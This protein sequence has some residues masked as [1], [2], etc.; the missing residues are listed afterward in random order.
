LKLKAAQSLAL[1]ALMGSRTL[2]PAE[3]PELD[4][5]PHLWSPEHRIQQRLDDDAG[6]QR[7]DRAVEDGKLTQR[8]P[9]GAIY[10]DGAADP[11][12]LLPWELF[13]SL[14]MRTMV[15]EDPSRAL[16]RGHFEQVR[17]R[18]GLPPTFWT[19]LESVAGH[20]VG[21][22]RAQMRLASEH[23]KNAAA[24]AGAMALL[25]SNDCAKR[26]QALA[27]ARAR[28]GQERFDRFLYEAVAPELTVVDDA[29]AL[30]EERLLR[31]EE[32]CP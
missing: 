8:P 14:I 7:I 24:N 31:V 12:L 11:E 22:L 9:S 27:A 20:F 28:F 5:Q 13:Q 6:R 1:F 26:A 30:D 16:N 29:S 10:V 2:H 25:Q 32:G 15:A 4:R 17:R 21:S 23:P 18:L 3:Q 19:D